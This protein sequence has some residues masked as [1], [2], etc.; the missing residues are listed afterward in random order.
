MSSYY[1]T[2]GMI[3]R[4]RNSDRLFYDSNWLTRCNNGKR[5]GRYLIS[6][7][8]LIKSLEEDVKSGKICPGKNYDSDNHLRYVLS[9][10]E[11]NHAASNKIGFLKYYHYCGE[12]HNGTYI[13]LIDKNGNLTLEKRMIFELDGIKTRHE[14]TERLFGKDHSPYRCTCKPEKTG[15]SYSELLDYFN[16]KNPKTDYD[17]KS[18]E[19]T[20]S[21]IAKIKQW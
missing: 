5:T 9:Y 14:D 6:P 13:Y 18:I 17:L 19:N 16:S 11:K 21:R 10:N 8:H 2:F 7:S 15:F 1:N 4:H 12:F 3:T 20:K